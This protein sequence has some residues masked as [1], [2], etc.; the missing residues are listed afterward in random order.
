MDG[1]CGVNALQLIL[2]D[3]STDPEDRLRAVID[4][5]IDEFLPRLAD[6][7]C[8]DLHELQTA[9][10][11]ELAFTAGSVLKPE[12]AL[13]FAAMMTDAIH[14]GATLEVEG[15]GTDEVLEQLPVSGLH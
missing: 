4:T 9:L 6:Q 12:S 7:A 14:T 15:Q 2:D 3:L 8:L 5:L 1:V 11:V 13:Q 10:A